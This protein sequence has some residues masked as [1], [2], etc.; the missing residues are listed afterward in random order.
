MSKTYLKKQ[1][2][3]FVD[4]IHRFNKGQQDA[5]LPH[6]EDGSIILIGATTENPG[7]EVNA[8]LISRSQVYV[9][10]PLTDSEME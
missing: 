6:V 7:F 5:F 2:V 1:T 10:Y 8:P 4:E 9:L 3:L